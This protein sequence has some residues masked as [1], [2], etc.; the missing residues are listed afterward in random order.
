MNTDTASGGPISKQVHRM[1][2]KIESK[3]ESLRKDQFN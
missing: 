2:K 3:N 1:W